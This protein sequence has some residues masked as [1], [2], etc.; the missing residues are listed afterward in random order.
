MSTLRYDPGAREGEGEAV[1][2]T[3]QSQDKDV[4]LAA[5]TPWESPGPELADL[6][7]GR[8]ET[9]AALT[10]HFSWALTESC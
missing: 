4:R 8:G 3:K 7:T 1:E 5:Q 9:T 10:F 6:S 2:P